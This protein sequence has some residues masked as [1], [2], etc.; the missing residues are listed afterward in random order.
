[1]PYHTYFRGDKD[2]SYLNRNNWEKGVLKEG[3]S[4]K[5]WLDYSAGWNMGWNIKKNFGVFIDSEYSKMWASE[6]FNSMLGI[7]Y[8]F[9]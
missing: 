1:M 8:Q 7:N 9:K 2:K 4:P 6:L 5:Q 3:L